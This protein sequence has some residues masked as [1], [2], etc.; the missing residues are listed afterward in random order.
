[1]S[2]NNIIAVDHPLLEKLRQLD[3]RTGDSG[4]LGDIGL[5]INHENRPGRCEVSPSDAI[6]FAE[7]GGDGDH[8]SLI[9]INGTVTESSPVVLTWPPEGENIAV[10][11]DLK[12]FLSV[13]LHCGYFNYLEVRNPKYQNQKEDWF[14][15][16]LVDED[17]EKLRFLSREL[18]I[19]PMPP[20]AMN[21]EQL[22]DLYAHLFTN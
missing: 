19:A 9:A 2:Q 11:P 15:D 1:M 20:E 10:A 16:D 18:N 3:L 7:T 22:N 5:Y 13:G 8:F 4:F 12:T 17:K 14:A 6:V 21:F